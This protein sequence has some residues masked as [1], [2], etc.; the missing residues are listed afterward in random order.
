MSETKNLNY[1]SS[2][3]QKL[4]VAISPNIEV[5]EQGYVWWNSNSD[6]RDNAYPNKLIDLYNNASAVHSNFINLK[7]GLIFGSGLQPLDNNDAILKQFLDAYNRAGNKMNDIFK[8]L[9]AD[10]A[11]FEACALQ[12]IYNSEGIA[13]VY[14]C[15]PANLRASAPNE[16]GYSEFWY[17]STRWGIISNKRMRKPANLLGDAVKIAN[18]NPAKGKSDKRQILYMKKYSSSQED[19]YPT[20]SYNAILNYVQLSFELSQ[21]HLNKVQN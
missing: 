16:F 9:A 4:Y 20:P 21:F 1:K 15:S 18:W 13:E 19:I 8:K 17:Y 2:E 10:M 12:V 14:H 5:T 3:L 7:S 6:L 11:L